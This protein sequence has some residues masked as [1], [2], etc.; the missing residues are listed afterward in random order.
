MSETYL[1][2]VDI[3]NSCVLLQDHNNWT[4][5][6]SAP[7]PDGAMVLIVTP[8][9]ISLRLLNPPVKCADWSDKDMSAINDLCSTDATGVMSLAYLDF[10]RG[11]QVMDDE[12]MALYQ[13]TWNSTSRRLLQSKNI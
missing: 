13:H 5:P 9:T 2:H 8:L 4:Y 3:I 1:N 12:P 11:P 6:L 10:C 7:L